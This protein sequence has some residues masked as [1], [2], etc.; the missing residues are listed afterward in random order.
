MNNPIEGYTFPDIADKA[1]VDKRVVYLETLLKQKTERTAFAVLHSEFAFR[2]AGTM[3]P[4]DLA[5]KCLE[6]TVKRG[7]E[8]DWSQPR[9][10]WFH[11]VKGV[12]VP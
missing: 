1:Y 4:R 10:L 11:S 7:N 6:D 3:F 12:Y 2:H 5:V 8:N 9:S